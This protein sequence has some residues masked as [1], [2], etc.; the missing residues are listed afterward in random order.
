LPPSEWFTIK[1]R[2]PRLRKNFIS[3]D[4][5]RKECRRLQVKS[6]AQQNLS[7]HDALADIG[8]WRV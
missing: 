6:E 2:L 4:E 1:D 8:V 7:P 5:Y 3:Y